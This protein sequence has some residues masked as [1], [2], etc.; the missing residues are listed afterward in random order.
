[1]AKDLDLD[2]RVEGFNDL[3]RRIKQV[4]ADLDKE[5]GREWKRIGGKVVGWS[6]SRRH[7]LEGRF[8]SYGA[9]V[10]KV[11]PSASRKY[12][13]VTVRPQAAERGTRRH[14][15]FGTW[16]AQSTFKR[17]VWPDES[18]DGWLVRPTVDEHLDDI[19]DDVEQTLQRLARRTIGD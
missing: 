6:E 16:M 12:L 9:D 3:R 18:R 15:V 11:K 5:L 1:M 13:Q 17:R 2:I 10:V 7:A 4:D 19:T 8:P 14:P